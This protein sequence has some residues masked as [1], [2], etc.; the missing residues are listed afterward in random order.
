MIH[1]GPPDM[2]CSYFLC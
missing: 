1:L 2:F